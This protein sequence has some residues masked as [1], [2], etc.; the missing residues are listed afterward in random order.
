MQ[1]Q[2]ENQY[3]NLKFKDLSKQQKIRFV[4]F[5]IFTLAF[6]IFLCVFADNI[7]VKTRKTIGLAILSAFAVFL[8]ADMVLLVWPDKN[9]RISGIIKYNSYLF[10]FD[11]EVLPPVYTEKTCE[12][13]FTDDSEICVSFVRLKKKIKSTWDAYFVYRDF[14]VPVYRLYE[15]FYTKELSEA[16]A[17]EFKYPDFPDLVSELLNFRKENPEEFYDILNRFIFEEQQDTL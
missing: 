10:N 1:L 7:E 2:N 5:V 4:A 8:L 9:Q 12:V 16:E 17:A 15:Y 13:I 11:F 3:Y 14:H 6:I